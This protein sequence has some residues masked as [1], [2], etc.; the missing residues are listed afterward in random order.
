MLCNFQ[1]IA[2]SS[3]S[4]SI[5]V[6]MFLVSYTKRIYKMRDNPVSAV[7][8]NILIEFHSFFNREGETCK[9]PFFQQASD[10][11]PC[12]ASPFLVDDTS[13]FSPLF[14][15][16]KF[17]FHSIQPHNQP[18][19]YSIFCMLLV[20]KFVLKWIEKEQKRKELAN[21]V[22]LTYHHHHRDH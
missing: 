13:K 16:I 5:F 9:L 8:D 17:F 21:F 22:P 18:L 15:Y 19:F 12:H 10:S 11:F 3:F 4:L 2:S 14:Y 7:L 1:K 6:E 20:V